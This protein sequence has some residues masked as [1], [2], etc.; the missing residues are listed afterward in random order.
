[1][2]PDPCPGGRRFQ[3]DAIPVDARLADQAALIGDKSSSIS[4]FMSQHSVLANSVA[5][6]VVLLAT[7][8]AAQ[9]AAVSPEELSRGRRLF[10]ASCARCHGVEGVGGETGP[11]LNQP[12]LERAPDDEA[13]S[14]V[15]LNGIR[16]TEM[17]GTRYLNDHQVAILAAYVRSLGR[18]EVVELPGDAENGRALFDGEGACRTCHIVN[19]IGDSLGPDL[20]QVGARRGAEFLEQHVKDPGSSVPESFLMLRVRTKA[21]R[22]VEGMRVNEDAFTLQ[23]RDSENEYHSF[24]KSDLREVR[25]QPGKTMMPSYE[26]LLS[27]AEIDDLVAYLATL[28]ERQ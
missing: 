5:A 20:T 10:E 19:G 25:R 16:G 8:V 28:R 13:L 27:D 3:Q 14:Q 22:T 15:I 23:L 21:G 17:P 9:E 11:T 26:V 7:L 1:V 12:T 24:L 6:S 4:A 2:S 18:R